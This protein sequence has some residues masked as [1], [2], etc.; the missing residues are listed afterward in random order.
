MRWSEDIYEINKRGGWILFL[1]RSEFSKLVNVNSTFIREMR[2]HEF[3]SLILKFMLLKG[4][5]RWLDKLREG[6]VIFFYS[7]FHFKG[8]S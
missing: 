3:A 7:L 8:C 2:V 5:M 4:F 1:W 6:F